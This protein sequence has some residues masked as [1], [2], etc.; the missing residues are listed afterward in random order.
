M[1]TTHNHTHMH[2]LTLAYVHTMHACTHTIT[3]THACVCTHTHTH[4]HTHTH[5]HMHACISHTTIHTRTHARTHTWTR[6]HIHTCMH[7]CIPHTIIQ[8]HTRTHTKLNLYHLALDATCASWEQVPFSRFSISQSLFDL[9]LTIACIPREDGVI[10]V[11]ILNDL[12]RQTH[13]IVFS[14]KTSG[15]NWRTASS[16]LPIQFTGIRTVEYRIQ[17]GLHN[18]SRI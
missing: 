3:H 14:Q 7:A 12:A 17:S 15:K 9:K 10:V 8:T 5:T 4:P 2:I 11:S 1:H 18:R 16:F 13:C 6:T